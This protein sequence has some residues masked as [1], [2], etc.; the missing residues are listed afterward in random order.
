[1]R[2]DEPHA[3]HLKDYRPADF[4][5]SHIDLDF[6]LEPESTRVAA[7]MTVKRTGAKAAPLV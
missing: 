2:T 5:I 3:I 1:M 4:R 6:V 7:K